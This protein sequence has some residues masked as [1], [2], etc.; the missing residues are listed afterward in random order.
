MLW[1]ELKEQKERKAEEEEKRKADALRLE[2]A[3]RK[4]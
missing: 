2:E 3:E 4:M 1:T